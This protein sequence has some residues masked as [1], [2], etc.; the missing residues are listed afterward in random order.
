M[1]LVFGW[2]ATC[3]IVLGVACVAA[4]EATTTSAA[5]SSTPPPPSTASQSNATSAPASSTTPTSPTT[6]AVLSSPNDGATRAATP[7]ATAHVNATAT[8]AAVAATGVSATLEA[9]SLSPSVSAAVEPSSVVGPD[10]APAPPGPLARPW[11]QVWARATQNLVV[12]ATP[13]G[14]QAPD[15]GPSDG[16]GHGEG[17]TSGAATPSAGG[18]TGSSAPETSRNALP[19]IVLSMLPDAPTP[20][21]LPLP[22][23]PGLNGPAPLAAGTDNDPSTP[24]P[25]LMSVPPAPGPT[26]MAFVAT[27][28]LPLFAS[29]AA[30]GSVLVA[31]GGGTSVPPAGRRWL[32]RLVAPLAFFSRLTPEDL[33]VNERRAQLHDFVRENPG[34]RLA[35]VRDRLGLS[36]GVMLHH[37]AI[38]EQRR[39]VRVVRGQG[40]TRLYPAGPRI[41]PE[42]YLAPT[43]RR[44]LVAC[45]LRPGGTQREIAR[46][47]GLSD[48]M[49]SYHVRWLREQGLLHVERDQGAHRCYA[50]EPVTAALQTPH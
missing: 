30:V 11:E 49:M 34:E 38:L 31:A 10:P 13:P 6:S 44:I 8:E 17:P 26:A 46:D 1:R 45:R 12:D 32:A 19:A 41:D 43:R 22:R 47:L 48:R 36:N 21:R 16:P 23:L 7:A 39:L 5:P 29:V 24:R 18:T 15:S 40:I 37:L 25:V 20:V 27:R 4:G 50:R 42:P 28:S 35:I 3:T 2:I 33:L 14:P 9:S